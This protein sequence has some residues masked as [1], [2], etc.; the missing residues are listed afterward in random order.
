MKRLPLSIV[1]R[2]LITVVA[3]AIIAPT[4]FT[5]APLVAQEE[6]AADAGEDV[7][8]VPEG[9]A[10]E[11]QAYMKKLANTPPEGETEEA[12]I[13]FSTKALNSL[14]TAADRLLAAKPD[15]MQT[16]QAHGFRIQALEA[17]TAM[18]QEGAQE[19]F[20]KAI[21]EAIASK[22]EDIVGMGWQTLIGD[23]TNRWDE[24]D[25][26]AKQSFRDEIISRIKTDGPN[27]MDVSIVQVTALQLDQLGQPEFLVKLLE[28]AMPL[29][30]KSDDKEVTA[31]L[32]EANLDGMLR[33]LKLLGNPI[34]IKGDLLSGGEVDWDSYRG[35]V[36]LVDF[37]ATWC[38]PCRAEVP[39]ILAMY[40]AYHDKGFEVLGVSLDKTPEAANKYKKEMK[41]PW[42]SLFPKN[43]DERFW[44]H[45]LARYYGIGGIPTAI[46]VDKDG[47]VVHMEARGELLQEQLQ[48]LLG[49]PVEKKPA[50]DK[51]E[52][53]VENTPAKAG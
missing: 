33:R 24:L 16:K 31:A 27:P 5:N 37:W 42:D 18:G 4:M 26:K 13:E 30:A 15:E 43:E 25:D 11:L 22:D 46:L 53:G 35:K 40:D 19:K 32:A 7:F 34:E 49:D 41:L 38:G 39:N 1:R 48:R 52:T 2:V 50:A 51:A 44:N 47:K 23:V 14:V 9:D 3:L 36:V 28:E 8:K 29:L 10:N 21:K 12:Q 6:A 45:P 20:Q 17:L